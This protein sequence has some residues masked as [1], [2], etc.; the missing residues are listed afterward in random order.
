MKLTKN[1][2]RY[3]FIGFLLILIGA[4]LIYIDNNRT[5]YSIIGIGVLF[6]IFGINETMK[7]I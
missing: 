6:L 7:S 2:I 4:F 5:Y 3:Y 1:S